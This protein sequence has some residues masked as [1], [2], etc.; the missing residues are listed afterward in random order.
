MSRAPAITLKQLSCLIAVEE[1]LHFRRAAERCGMSQ[2]ALSAQIQNLELALGAQVLE[3]S[4]AGVTL[5]PIGREVFARARE[6]VDGA[7]AIIDLSVAS[8]GGLMGTIKLGTSATLGPYLLPQVVSTL[9]K[10]YKGLSLYVW[11]SSPLDLEYD[12]GRGAHDVILAQLPTV[13]RD[14]VVDTLFREPLYLALAV[15]HPLAQ[16]DHIAVA[17]L[18]GLDVLSLSPQYH[19]HRQVSDLCQ[20]F[21]ARMLRDYEGTSLDALRQM[22]G[23]GMGAAFLP[24][25]YVRSEITDRGGGE[26]I[27]RRIKGRSIFRAVGLVWRRSAGRSE[28]YRM[29]AG[30]IRRVAR[31]HF[32]DLQVETDPD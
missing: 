10:K 30:I 3:R 32:A 13:S 24:A 5:T 14:F 15:D 22:V 4:R 21:G 19:L 1:T 9:H 12:L 20:T 7:Q 11:E 31:A 17:D 2:P 23:M 6:V 8:R 27:V 28:Q 25:L 18:E 26:I 29:I 16:K